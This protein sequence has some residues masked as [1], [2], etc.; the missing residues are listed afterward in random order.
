MGLL[1]QPH[2][3]DSPGERLAFGVEVPHLLAGMKEVCQQEET[4]I[5]LAPAAL[6]TLQHVYAQ[7]TCKVMAL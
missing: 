7:V 5:H 2:D 3:V 4:L 6:H 1:C